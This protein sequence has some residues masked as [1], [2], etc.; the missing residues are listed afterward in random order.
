MKEDYGLEPDL[1]SGGFSV[2]IACNLKPEE[3]RELPR[4]TLN[5][6]SDSYEE[7]DSIETD[8]D[9]DLVA[10]NSDDAPETAPETAPQEEER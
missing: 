9:D 8:A 3:T 5:G 6:A 4:A 7:Y 10:S 1:P 2:C